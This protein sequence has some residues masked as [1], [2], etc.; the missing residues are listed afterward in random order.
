MSLRLRL[1]VVIS[2]LVLGT[3]TILH[4]AALPPHDEVRLGAE[5]LT[6]RFLKAFE[7][8]DI[9]AFMSC[10]AP[11]AT[12]FFPIPEPPQ[13]FDGEAAIREHFQQ[14][15][16]AIRRTSSAT[17]PPFHHLNPEDLEVQVL[18]SDAAVVTFHLR[19]SERIA[20][21]TLVISK[22]GGDW[23]IRHLHASNVPVAAPP[24]G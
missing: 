11:D 23:R 18:S 16:A 19:N 7:N 2:L 14:V 15:F 17:A 5:Q 20:R 9:D 8:L 24:P 12:V 4:L 21:R 6:A 13:R 10:F 1:A 3:T 22:V